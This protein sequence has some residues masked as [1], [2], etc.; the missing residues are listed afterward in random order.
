MSREDEPRFDADHYRECI[1]WLLLGL[2]IQH[3]DEFMERC[4]PINC[5]K[6]ALAHSESVKEK[7]KRLDDFERAEREEMGIRGS[8]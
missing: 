4:T 1:A 3:I 6:L 7:L 5:H 2:G 8:L